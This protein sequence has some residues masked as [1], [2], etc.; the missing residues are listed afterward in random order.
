MPDARLFP[1]FTPTVM[2]ARLTR[3]RC[4][5]R[6]Q[7]DSRLSALSVGRDSAPACLVVTQTTRRVRPQ[8]ACEGRG[9]PRVSREVDGPSHPGA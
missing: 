9:V 7:W 4:L 8:K 6:R 1:S 3:S 2:P 5:I